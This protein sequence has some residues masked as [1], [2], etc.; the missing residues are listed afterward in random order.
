MAAVLLCAGSADA[1]SLARRLERGS[2]GTYDPRRAAALYCVGAQA[3][4]ADAAFA[5]GRLYLAGRGVPRNAAMGAA[6]LRQAARMGRRDAV[7]LIPTLGVARLP[8]PGCPGV[9][10]GIPGGEP[11]AELAALARRQAERKGIDPALVLAMMRIESGFRVRAVSPKG[12][13]GLMQLM[14]ATAERF[15]VEDAY[16]AEQNLRGGVAYLRFLL[17]RYEGDVTLA[18]A[19]YNAGEGAVDNYGGV[20]PYAETQAYV[21]ALHAI[22]PRR[23]HQPEGNTRRTAG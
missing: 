12:A 1:E 4:D 20:P 2:N 3:G 14:P 6:W 23:Q 8:S 22:Y 11:P 15:G 7:K 21:Q 13:M 10:R 16:D 5:L 9:R 17:D 18:A 19:A